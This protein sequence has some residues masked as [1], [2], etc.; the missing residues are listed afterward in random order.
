MNVQGALEEMF[1][2][3]DAALA[4]S[5]LAAGLRLLSH[6]AERLFSGRALEAD[7]TR[8]LERQGNVCS[9]WTRVRVESGEGLESIRGNHF[10]GHVFL[11]G[12]RGAWTDSD[13]RDWAAGMEDCRV[14]DCVIGNASLYGI[15]RLDRQVIEDGAVL[16]GLGD[17]SCP[18]ATLFGLGASF[19]PGTESGARCAWMWD[20]LTVADCMKALSLPAEA[21]A[22][23][24]KRLDAAL[25][26][27]RCTFG[28]VGKGASLQHARRI[29][30]AWIGP[31][32]VVS[33]ASLIGDSALLSTP[34]DPCVA[35]EDAWIE[36][37]L[38]APGVR[39]ESGGKVSC[40]MLLA[41]ASVTWGGMVSQSLIGSH[42]QVAK[43]EITS[44][45][46]GPFAGL[47]HQS[48][49]ISALWPEGRGNI[50]YGANVG[51]NHT[52]KK[53]DQEIRPG[54]GNFFGLACSVKFPAN[55]DGAPYSLFATGVSLPPQ[56]LAF[57]FSLISQPLAAF[58]GAAAGLNE[59]LPA[60]MWSDNAYSLVRRSYKFL[61]AEA[62]ANGSNPEK[63]GAGAAG[64]FEGRVFE[65]AL[66]VKVLKARQ[67]LRAAP[68]DAPLLL[69]E[70]VPGL[71]KNALRGAQRLRALSAYD[72]YL[73]LFL[74]RI[75]A[76]RPQEAWPA[77][78]LTLAESIA[79]ELEAGPDPKAYLAAQRLRL[80]AF[81][82]AILASLSR[83]DLRGRAI[84]DDY[85]E[86][87]SPPEEDKAV[88][89]LGRDLL[90]LSERL[91]AYLSKG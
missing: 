68:A 73:C 79:R 30:A 29:R 24:R 85:A 86:F 55:Y 57:P 36:H 63:T 3:A 82:E 11:S 37:S 81:R 71:G 60:W 65:P 40:S 83:E 64:F 46:V 48:L 42:A 62:G 54:E 51:S 70:Q 61:D 34:E 91:E 88:I 58:P 49:L 39:V 33:G 6:A 45:L 43:G 19:H 67:A 10:D 17:L 59:I 53:P 56:R 38:L 27:L 23:V 76:H 25:E 2:K 72:D 9:D 28:Y 52:G 80:P 69:E 44:S 8:L 16:A 75:H 35:A 13:G 4:D 32:A 41:R 84:H 12:F 21:Q 5:A 77:D 18:S 26:P 90:A 14:R 1:A 78:L 50:A 89:R 31:G 74:I 87:H 7:E 22:E 66:A 20:A 47:H 15:V